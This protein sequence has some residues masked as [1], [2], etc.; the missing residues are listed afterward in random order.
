MKAVFRVDASI[1]IGSGHV[2]RCLVLANLL[3][4]YHWQ[5]QFACIKQQGALIELITQQGFDVISLPASKAMRSPQFDGDHAAWLISTPLEDA[6]AFIE[7]VQTTDWVIVD[8]YAIGSDWEWQIK[9]ELKCQVLVIDDLNREHCSDIILDQNI[10]PDMHKRYIHFRG[11][12]LLGYQY[13]LLQPSFNQ[14]KSKPPSKE[15]QILVFFGGTDPTN[16]C[17]KL[18]KAA[19]ELP[20]LPFKLKVLTGRQNNHYQALLPYQLINRIELVPFVSNFAHELAVSKYCIGA[21]GI[22]NW[23]RFCL[24]VPATVVCV[25]NNQLQLSHYLAKQGYI[26]FLGEGKN[27]DVKSYQQELL[28]LQGRWQSLHMFNGPNVD[29]LGAKRVAQR[30]INVGGEK[31]R[32]P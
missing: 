6:K 12:R 25:A 23:E 5:I 4:T 13:A 17:E 20:K 15:N 3:K 24:G 26:F 10:W 18:V 1:W 29:G 32:K 21:A 14:L 9:T 27:T 8:H 16:E 2:M 31:K 30:M 28:R 19:F 7:Q 22:S 11:E